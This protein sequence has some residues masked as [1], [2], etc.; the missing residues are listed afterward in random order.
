MRPTGLVARRHCM[1]TAVLVAAM[2][3]VLVLAT[4]A[5]A[6]SCVP[7]TGSPRTG[8]KC[9]S[10]VSYP[11]VLLLANQSYTQVLGLPL[12]PTIFFHHP[13]CAPP[14]RRWSAIGQVLELL[15]AVL[16]NII[17]FYNLIK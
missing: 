15:L 5:Q 16:R 13:F 2:L 14:C 6:Q 4:G 10:L 9:D 12:P 7:F 11:S 3:V 17:Y 8:H 1:M